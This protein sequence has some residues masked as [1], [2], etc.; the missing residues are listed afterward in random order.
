MCGMLM[1]KT[2]LCHLH[3]EEAIKRDLW[4]AGRMSGVMGRLTGGGELKCSFCLVRGQDEGTG[5][6]GCLVCYGYVVSG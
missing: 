3:R 6:W 2:W 1:R 5:C 4:R